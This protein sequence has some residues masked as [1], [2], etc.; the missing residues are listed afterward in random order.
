MASFVY[1]EAKRA[2]CEGEIDLGN[3]QDT[4]KI[5]LVLEPTSFDTDY[6]IDTMGAATTTGYFDGANHDSTNGHTLLNQAV[7]EVTGVS[8]YAKFLADDYTFTAL[9]AGAT[10]CVGIVLLKWITNM[11]SSLPLA[12]IDAADFNG[13][14]G[15]V[16]IEWHTDGILKIGG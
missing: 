1:N 16:I 15:D 10:A 14:G 2:M 12:Y 6:D 9:G 5:V 13:S 4:I 3:A 7:T 11:A 8:G